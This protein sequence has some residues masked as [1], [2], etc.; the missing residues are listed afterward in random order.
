MNA[1]LWARVLFISMCLPA[2]WVHSYTIGHIYTY[3]Y[4]THVDVDKSG[5][6]FELKAPK[7][8][9]LSLESNFNAEFNI[10]PIRRTTEGSLIVKL[11][12]DHII[13]KKTADC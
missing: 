3:S 12:V 1:R 2:S 6:T 5:L 4:S 7:P 9:Q 8:P 10:E 11:Q 13:K